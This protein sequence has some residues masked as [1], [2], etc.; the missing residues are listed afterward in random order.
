[1]K[2]KDEVS[3]LIDD[4]WGYIEALIDAHAVPISEARVAKYHY[5]AAMLHGWKHAKEDSGEAVF[6]PEGAEMTT[7]DG[8][9]VVPGVF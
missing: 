8:T 7:L 3:K 4:H 5:K 6:A 2:T 9:K 1:M